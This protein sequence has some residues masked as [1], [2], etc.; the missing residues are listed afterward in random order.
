MTTSVR[1][2]CTADSESGGKEPAS[3]LN[4]RA[5]LLAAISN[6]SVASIIVPKPTSDRHAP[7]ILR[8]AGSI[9]PA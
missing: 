7:K 2:D 5:G 4:A 9:G 8:L 3:R 1:A 6:R